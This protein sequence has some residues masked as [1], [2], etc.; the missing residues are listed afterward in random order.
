VGHRARAGIG[1]SLLQNGGKVE[2]E[3][4]ARQ[5]QRLPDRVL[6]LVGWEVDE[7]YGEVP[8]E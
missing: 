8:D 4:L 5:A 1:G 3:P 2:I 7:A 6:D